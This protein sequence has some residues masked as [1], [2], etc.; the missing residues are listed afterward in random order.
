MHKNGILFGSIG[1]IVETSE[2]QRHAFNRAFEQAGLDWHWDRDFYRSQ[3]AVSGG[4]NR[5]SRFADERNETVDA[6]HVHQQKT[7][8][9]DQ[10]M[11]EASLAPRPGV[12]EVIEFAQSNGYA[13]GFVTSTS[14][15]NIDAVFAALGEHINA[16]IFDFVGLRELVDHPKPDPAIYLEALRA[17]D[18]P[19]CGCVAIEDSSPS[20]AAAVA[21]DIA[22]IAFP[23]ENTSGHDFSGSALTTSTLLTDHITQLLSND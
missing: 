23:G 14:Q 16:G 3:L 7:E 17:L 10:I 8:I 12:N 18:I 11:A 5:I 20:L 22:C 21:A 2:L 6:K 13:L 1:T 9:L 15:D 19:A 4:E